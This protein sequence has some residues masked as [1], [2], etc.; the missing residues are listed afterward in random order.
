MQP[1]IVAE[2]AA[3][4]GIRAPAALPPSERYISPNEAGRI[5]NVTGE[6]V[7]QWIYHRRLPATKLS[8]G[9]W[10][11]KVSDLE[12]F[13][14]ARSNLGQRKIMI[15]DAPSSLL[16]EIV[17]SLEKLGH[18]TIVAHSWADAL[19][20]A[21]DLYPSLF[22]VNVSLPQFDVWKLMERVRHTRNIRNAPIMIMAD[23]DL[24]DSEAEAALELNVQA[25]LRRPF[26]AQVLVEEIQKILGR[27]M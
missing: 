27:I 7:K 24:K 10:K 2:E 6:A 12:D 25:F 1:I 22:I 19:L 14:K 8:N 15:I 21:A 11:I 18:Q 20:K 9:Y 4:Y 26:R 16:A 3:Q 23:R 5:L 17:S 13:I